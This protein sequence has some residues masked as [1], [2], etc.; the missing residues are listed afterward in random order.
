MTEGVSGT[1]TKPAIVKSGDSQDKKF[2]KKGTNTVRPAKFEGRCDDLKSHVYDYGEH[3]SADLFIVTTKEIAN[4]VGRTYKC[5]GD[6]A[7][8]I[9]NLEAPTK[10]QPVDPV[11]PDN[12]VIM[13]KWEREYDEYRKWNVTMTESIKTLYNLV[14]GQCSET[15]QQKLE[16]LD[17]YTDIRAE[18]DGI[19]LLLAI[20]NTA[21]NYNDE[22]YVFESVIEAQYR[23]MVL[24]QNTMTPQQYYEKFSNLVSVYIHCGGSSDP[25]PGLYEHVATEQGWKTVTEKRK[26][27]VKEMYWATLFIL[28]ADPIRYGGLIM[29]LQ[30][31]YLTEIDK[32]PKTMTAALSRLT[33]WK[34]Q[35]ANVRMN[36]STSNGVSFTNVGDTH[37]EGEAIKVETT[38]TTGTRGPRVPRS[39]A[40]ITCFAC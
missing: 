28:H 31:D 35:F 26:A 40:Y 16:S 21:Y 22:K 39:K 13:K 27:E 34:S 14:W 3:R 38:K 36:N 37:T 33:N 17:D 12:K 30:N 8:A 9:I 29:D 10:T 15:M 6:L 2:A 19:G 4:H 7:E 18:S 24:R 5:G 25:D 11:N 20:K 1:D 23:V 32:Y